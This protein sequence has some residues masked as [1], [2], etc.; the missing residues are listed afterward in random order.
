MSPLRHA[1]LGSAWMAV[2]VLTLAPTA[3]AEESWFQFATEGFRVLFPSK[4]LTRK[5]TTHTP[6][7]SIVDH[8]H[9]VKGRS[10]TYVAAVSGLPHAA[11]LFAGEDVIYDNAK[12]GILKDSLGRPLD[13]QDIE[14][15][16]HSGKS[17][18]Y[19]LPAKA[20]EPGR[21]GR[22]EMYLVGDKLYVF[23]VQVDQQGRELSA[24]FFESIQLSD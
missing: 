11:I 10:G 6:V 9:L 7:G 20:N 14:R 1:T 2:V 21:R 22:A 16:G 4:P 18:R 3:Q 24:R 23:N 17:L 12:G 8:E 13:F 15:D 5:I 19:E